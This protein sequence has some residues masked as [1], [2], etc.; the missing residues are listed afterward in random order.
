MDIFP[1]KTSASG[2]WLWRALVG[3][4]GL[5]L[6]FAFWA[7]LAFVVAYAVTKGVQVA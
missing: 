6:N 1:I 4:T 7:A 5:I 2:P 3:L